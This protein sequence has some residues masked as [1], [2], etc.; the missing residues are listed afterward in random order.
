MNRHEDRRH[1]PQDIKADYWKID[2][3]I[4]LLFIMTLII[5]LAV[6]VVWATQLDARVG[7]IELQ[8]NDTN[9]LPERFAR[10]EERLDNVKQDTSAMK[11]SLS[12]LTE[13]LLSK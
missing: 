8:S 13:K 10:L 1:R 6:I 2:K 7:R 11:Q 3:R 5:Q 4:P 12:N 9:N